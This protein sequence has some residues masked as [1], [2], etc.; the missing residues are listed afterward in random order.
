MEQWKEKHCRHCPHCGRVVEKMSGCDQMRCGHDAHGGNEQRGCGKTFDWR[1]A[2]VYAAD[3]RSAA[4]DGDGKEEHAKERRLQ[5]DAKEEHLLVAGAPVLCDGCGNPIIGPRLQCVQCAGCVDLCIGCV[6]KAART[7]PLLLR[8]GTK[9]PKQ[10]TFRRIRQPPNP[11]RHA[12]AIDL[13]P[14]TVDL[15]AS[16][17]P[18][19]SSRK[20][21]IDLTGAGQGVR[22]SRD[23]QSVDLTGDDQ[24]GGGSSSSSR[25]RHRPVDLTSG[26]GSSSGQRKR[27][28]AGHGAVDLTGSDS[29]ANEVVCLE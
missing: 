28:T 3:L 29:M 21:P 27:P 15:G 17:P 14:S 24:S 8:D 26:Q 1:K 2:R 5:L 12:P 6:G 18:T 4:D 23:P 20:R 25:N 22:G 9:H 13:A 7:K 10:H 11:N 16:A 19:S